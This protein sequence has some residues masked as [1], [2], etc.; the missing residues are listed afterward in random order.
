MSEERH[1]VCIWKNGPGANNWDLGVYTSVLGSDGQWGPWQRRLLRHV[2]VDP[3][4]YDDNRALRKLLT[5]LRC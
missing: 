5:S 4:V 3:L 1:R 2:Y